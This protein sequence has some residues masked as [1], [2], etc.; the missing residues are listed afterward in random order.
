MHSCFSNKGLGD[1]ILNLHANTLTTWSG[2]LAGTDMF[3]W[4]PSP[5]DSDS[6]GLGESPGI[7]IFNKH[8]R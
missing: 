2:V 1:F 5:R 3:M 7:R 4:G 6:R 8:L